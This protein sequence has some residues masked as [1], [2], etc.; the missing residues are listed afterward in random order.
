MAKAG[1]DAFAEMGASVEE[2]TPA[3]GPDG[4]ELIRF[5]WAAHELSYVKYLDQWGARMDPGLVACI[6]SAENHSA[7]AYVEM[8]TR[9]LAYVEA[10]HRFFERYDLLLT[11]A[12]AALRR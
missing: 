4:P 8:R 7:E 5:F 2:V 1:A 6:R 9:K 12:V 3:W 10:I 11:P